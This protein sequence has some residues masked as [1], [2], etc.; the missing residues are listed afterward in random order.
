MRAGERS[1]GHMRVN[2]RSKFAAIQLS[3]LD[4][5]P[6]SHSTQ[7]LLV[8]AARVANTGMRWT[9][10]T[11][12]SIKGNFGTAPTRIEPVC[13]TLTLCGLSGARQVTIRALNGNGQPFGEPTLA[14]AVG[15]EFVIELN[16]KPGTPWY[17]INVER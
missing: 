1:T 7:L 13:A 4:D 14:L 17:V 12:S 10:E 2:L 5:L 8:A 11:R 3:S 9:D 16:E 15:D 6:V